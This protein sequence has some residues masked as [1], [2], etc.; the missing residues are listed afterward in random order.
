M[1]TSGLSAAMVSLVLFSIFCIVYM[2]VYFVLPGFQAIDDASNI[3]GKTIDMRANRFTDRAT[4]AGKQ[5]VECV[6]DGTENDLQQALFYKLSVACDSFDIL[7]KDFRFHSSAVE[8][9][10]FLVITNK[11]IFE[12]NFKQTLQVIYM[13]EAGLKGS[14]VASTAFYLRTENKKKVL[15]CDIFL[16]SIVQNTQ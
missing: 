3:D 10:S 2:L 7:F 14:R 15:S 9:D 11:A 6:F 1:R 5:Y 4:L 12:G 13:L 8:A 16:Q